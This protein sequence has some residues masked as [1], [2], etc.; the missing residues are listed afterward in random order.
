VRKSS[1]PW[2]IIIILV[3]AYAAGHALGLVLAALGLLV[4]Y[5]SSLRLHPRMRHRACRGTGEHHSALFPWTHRKCGGCQ[6]GRII[7]WGAGRWGAGHIRGEHV[8][9]R[10]ARDAARSN[11][12][13]R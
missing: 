6:G 13:W 5:I 8:S 4:V 7:R 9:T 3:V 1:F 12:E 10:E 11:R 2:A